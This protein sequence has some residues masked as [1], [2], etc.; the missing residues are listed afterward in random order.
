MDLLKFAHCL[1]G[2][3]NSQFVSTY[4]TSKSNMYFFLK[5]SLYFIK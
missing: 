3:K 4:T 5:C 1:L 2:Q